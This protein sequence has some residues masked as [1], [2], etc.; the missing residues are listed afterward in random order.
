[1][2]VSWLADREDPDD[3][4]GSTLPLDICDFGASGRLLMQVGI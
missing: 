1:M 4:M 2:F 3:L